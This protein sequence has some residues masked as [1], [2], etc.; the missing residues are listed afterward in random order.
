MS[1]FGVV[2]CCCKFDYFLAKGCVASVRHYLGDVPITLFVDGRFDASGLAKAFDVNVW[3]RDQ[4]KDAWLREFN[5][6]WGLPKMTLFWESPYERYL[7]LDCDTLVWGDVVAAHGGQGDWDMII[8]EGDL[9][10]RP[11]IANVGSEAWVNKEYFNTEK[12]ERLSPGFAWRKYAGEFFCSGT[13]FGRRGAI[14]LEEYKEVIRLRDENPGVFPIGEMG[15]LNFMIFRAADQGRLKLVRRPMELVCDYY[16]DRGV[17]RERMK[18]EEGAPPRRPER[19]MVLHFTDP[20]P[21]TDSRGVH[22]PFDYFRMEAL[23]RISGSGSG[24]R[25]RLE[26]LPW[27]ITTEYRQKYGRYHRWIKP[28]M[29]WRRADGSS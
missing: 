11:W 13:F 9:I 10:S 29:F 7:Y 28:F 2:V 24:W 18:F 1:D 19:A 21:L 3:Y 4:V 22:E 16:M 12:V 5:R 26:E 25:I 14:G 20:K 8:D 23:R 17:A 15:L 27:R 6:G